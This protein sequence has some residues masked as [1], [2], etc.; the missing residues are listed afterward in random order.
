MLDGTFNG[1]FAVESAPENAKSDLVINFP[2]ER[3][4]IM[5]V[6]VNHLQYDEC[7]Y[8]M[9]LSEMFELYI[10]CD[11]YNITN[12]SEKIIDELHDRAEQSEFCMRIYA[13][14][15]LSIFDGL[16]SYALK[17]IISLLAN[18]AVKY[19]CKTCDKD[20]IPEVTCE[21]CGNDVT[22]TN[23]YNKCICCM[24]IINA[25]G[26]GCNECGSDLIKSYFKLETGEIPDEVYAEILKKYIENLNN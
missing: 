18:P 26:D 12:V 4:K 24:G 10:A 14:C 9:E 8:D 21:A 11:K 16:K 23:K 17:N 20:V 7:A 1:S 25:L 19:E 5:K 22:I 2:D 3:S 13:N 15:N 6:I